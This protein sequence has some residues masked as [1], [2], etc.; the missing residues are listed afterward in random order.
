MK[1]K[2]VEEEERE[3]GQREREKQTNLHYYAYS[4][5]DIFE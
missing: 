5:F 2:W 3:T 4:T 1:A